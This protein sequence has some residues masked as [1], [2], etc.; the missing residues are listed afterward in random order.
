M[1]KFMAMGMDLQSVI[2]ATT[3]NAAKEIKRED[4]GSLSVGSV[5]DVAVFNIREG[6]FGFFDYTGYKM[7]A[8]KKLETELTIR[9]GKVVYNLNGINT[10]L[11]VDGREGIDRGNEERAARNE[12]RGKFSK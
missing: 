9:A 11:V 3:Q 4:L 10:P 8:T 2:K 6:K 12:K 1:S 7:D 5:A